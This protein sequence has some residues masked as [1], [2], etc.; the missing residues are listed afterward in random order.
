MPEPLKTV[1]RRY[2]EH[3]CAVAGTAWPKLLHAFASVPR[4]RFV[5]PAPWT[6]LS[7]ALQREVTPNCDPRHLYRDVLVALDEAKQLNNGQPSFWAALFDRLRPSP[8]DRVVHVGAGGGYYTAILAELVGPNGWVMGIEYEPWLAA[9]AASALSDRPNVELLSGDA[10]ALVEGPADVIVASCGFDH[11]PVRWVRAL[12]EGGRLMLPLTTAS[13]L[14][15]IGAGAVL[16]IT[17]RDEPFDEVAAMRRADKPPARK[18]PSIFDAE[19]VS[20]TMIYHDSAGR[21]GA[22]SRRIA[23]AFRL[24][25]H[26]AW[27][28]PK[29]ASL[30]LGGH[31]DETAWLTGDGWWL[32]TAPGR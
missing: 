16:M 31:P 22:A 4:E 10:H 15:G 20:G 27:S 25:R 9:A 17:R 5:G 23:E 32:S 26:A 12:T 14:P 6:I 8:A 21:S 28:P 24:S 1:R 2:A 18:E 11:I 29:V 13:P 3:V 19:F 7:G 30:R